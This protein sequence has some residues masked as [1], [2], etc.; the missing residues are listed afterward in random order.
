VIAAAAAAALAPALAACEAGAGAQ[1]SRP[2]APTD[3]GSTVLRDIAIRNMFVLG[4]R[5]GQT[6]PA[7]HSAGVFLALVNNGAPDQLLAI[8]APGTAASVKLPQRTIPLATQ[9]PAF[10]TGPAPKVILQ[11]LS[12]P[13][14]GGQWI[15][16]T[17]YFQNAGL[18]TINVPV[19]TW[20]QYYDTFS[21]PPGPT[22]APT[23]TARATTAPTA[24][25]TPA[26]TPS[27]GATASPTP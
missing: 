12:K 14:A 1:T 3:G 11:N 17:F 26:A 7:G 6:I 2:Y 15:Q 23:R 10:L 18:I 19:V 27:R 13:L 5:P 9:Q 4:P 22:P 21:P 8:D 25:A 16:M 20:A 24:R